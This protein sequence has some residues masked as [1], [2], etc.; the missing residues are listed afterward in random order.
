MSEEQKKVLL[1]L[2]SDNKSELFAAFSSTVTA[3]TKAEKW[4]AVLL[5]C[6]QDH[7]FDPTNG[8]GWQY[9]RDATWPNIKNYVMAKRDKLN[10]SGA[11]GG[12][13]ARYTEVDN[14]VL[15]IIGR[16]TPVM[17]GLQLTVDPDKR[18]ETSTQ[19][20]E[21]SKPS[22]STPKAR[23]LELQPTSSSSEIECLKI[24]KLRLQVEELQ[25]RCENWRLQNCRLRRLENEKGLTNPDVMEFA[26]SSSV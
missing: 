15:D 6:R 19:P 8:R 13:G 24:Q 1:K 12:D 26:C 7:G 14:I 17:D 2:I 11:E 16:E 25:L 22:H 9:L 23:R 18:E 10:Q 3:A 5:E 20:K 4:A 21:P